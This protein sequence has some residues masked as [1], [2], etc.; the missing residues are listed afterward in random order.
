M[1]AH[2]QLQSVLHSSA[3]SAGAFPLHALLHLRLRTDQ[4]SPLLSLYM[5][6]DD[7]SAPHQLCS[8]KKYE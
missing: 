7:V 1:L 5:C 2:Y 6:N 8:N 4:N 3:Q